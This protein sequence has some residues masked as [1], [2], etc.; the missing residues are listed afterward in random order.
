M[1]YLDDFVVY[2]DAENQVGAQ[3][4]K[5]KLKSTTDSQNLETQKFDNLSIAP[6]QNRT[7]TLIANDEP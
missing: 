2:D 3:V 7:S 6:L 5:Q 1:G 4:L